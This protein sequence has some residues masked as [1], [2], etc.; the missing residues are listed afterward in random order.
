MA[1]PLVDTSQRRVRLLLLASLFS[2]SESARPVPIV[3]E[4]SAGHGYTGGEKK[5]R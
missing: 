5:E 3:W 1:K 2:V 4:D